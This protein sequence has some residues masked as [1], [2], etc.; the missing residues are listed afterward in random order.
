MK[1]ESETNAAPHPPFDQQDVD[2]IVSDCDSPEV[3]RM[4]REGIQAAQEGRRS[5]A[6]TLLLKVTEAD[7]RNENAWLW[8]ASISEYPEELL[9]FLKN[10]LSINP[11][12]ERAL[13]W[14][15]ATEALMAKTFVQRGIE[16][17]KSDQKDLAK[18]CF[19]QAIVHDGRS[20]LAWLWLASVSDSLDEKVSHLQKVLSI[21]PDNETAAA[22]LRHAKTLMARSLMPQANQAAIAGRR[23][24]S[25]KLLDEILHDAPE[26]EDGWMLKAHLAESFE[27]KIAYFEQVLEVNPDNQ[28]ARANLDSLRQIVGSST[29]AD[30]PYPAE[31]SGLDLGQMDLPGAG[32]PYAEDESNET[33]VWESP[34]M[35]DPDSPDG[36]DEDEEDPGFAE[37]PFDEEPGFAEEPVDEEPNFAEEAAEEEPAYAEEAVEEEFGFADEAAVEEPSFEAAEEVDLDAAATDAFDQAA[38]ESG[39]EEPSAE[40]FGEAADE[41]EEEFSAP[42][43]FE[44]PETENLAEPEAE[45]SAEPA[46]E[47]FFESVETADESDA[48]TDAAEEPAVEETDAGEDFMRAEEEAEPDAKHTLSEEDWIEAENAAETPDAG[49]DDEAPYA[50]ESAPEE[51]VEEQADGEEADEAPIPDPWQ[52]FADEVSDEAEEAAGDDVDSEHEPAG[53]DEFSSFREEMEEEFA[54]AAADEE[55][56]VPAGEEVPVEKYT[57]TI[58]CQYCSKT[59]EHQVFACGF[60]RSV[61]SLSDIEMLLSQENADRAV[62]REAVERLETSR[63]NFGVSAAELKTLGIGYLNLK[64]YRRGM[65]CLRESFTKNPNDVMLSSQIDA[66]AIRVAEIEEKQQEQAAPPQSRKI[67]VVDDSP[68]VRKLISG[69]LEKCGHEAVCAVDGMDALAKISE[70][71]PDLV[72]LDIT[73]PR[74]DGYQVCKMIRSN[75][76]TK[77]VPVIMISGKDGFFDKV[78]GKMAGTTSYITKPFGPETLMKTINEY[79]G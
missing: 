21:N 25:L 74:M 52:S 61:I 4:L 71:V 28:V 48:E 70:S 58:V 54:R 50:F 34:E 63:E 68:T 27:E 18:Q 12:N 64:D 26:F 79:I 6:R 56:F 69:K 7:A 77:D 16:A 44:E 31:V 37:E 5:E 13:E 3:T 67:L 29:G 57:E 20:E 65:E 46:A 22:S 62:L 1:L 66:L 55:D 30:G 9:V 78:R 42:L 51:S 45:S 43:N 47:S 60:C 36:A 53:S 49:P 72:L 19:L 11:S 32:E 41:A 39:H 23:E 10:V 15:A 75:D 8:L 2:E 73:M 17:S 40:H 24:E 35:S 14:A 59:N 76:S 38:D 33:A